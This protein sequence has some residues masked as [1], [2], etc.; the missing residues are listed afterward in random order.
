VPP[1]E[2]V[3]I[4]AFTLALNLRILFVARWSR[5]ISVIIFSVTGIVG[6]KLLLTFH[7][8]VLTVSFQDSFS[9][10]KLSVNLC[11]RQ[12]I[13]LKGHVILINL[14]IEIILIH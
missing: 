12:V 2:K 6:N 1:C 7:S 10:K 4:L 14:I 13:S 9:Y 3:A 11:W 5:V 8:I